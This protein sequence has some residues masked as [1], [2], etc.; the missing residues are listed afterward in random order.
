MPGSTVT[1]R[2]DRAVT[3]PPYVLVSD[4]VAISVTTLSVGIGGPSWDRPKSTLFPELALTPRAGDPRGGPPRT[5][6][7]WRA[8]VTIGA[9]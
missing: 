5:G 2:S 1:V 9:R 4:W 3:R 7:P 6:G 8:A